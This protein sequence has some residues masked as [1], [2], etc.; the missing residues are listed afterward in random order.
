M[1]VQQQVACGDVICGDAIELYIPQKGGDLRATVSEVA[2]I[3]AL[4]KI[5]TDI[6]E[7]QFLPVNRSITIWRSVS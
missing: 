1:E 5:E 6:G 7:S 3:G 4:V 2:R